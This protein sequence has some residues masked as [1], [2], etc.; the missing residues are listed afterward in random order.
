MGGYATNN[1]HGI[2]NWRKNFFRVPKSKGNSNKRILPRAGKSAH[3]AVSRKCLSY[4]VDKDLLNKFSYLSAKPL[5]AFS[6]INCVHGILFFERRRISFVRTKQPRLKKVRSPP[7]VGS[8]YFKFT[9][10]SNACHYFIQ[11]L[12][13]FYLT[14]IM[15]H[16]ILYCFSFIF[17]LCFCLS[18]L[19]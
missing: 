17:L 6:S 4:H 15:I 8:S 5:C 7:G 18:Q 10:L 13:L 1:G 2:C 11:V 9:H 12:I 3:C 16:V 14:I 19:V